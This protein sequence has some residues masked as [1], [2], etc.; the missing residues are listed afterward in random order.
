MSGDRPRLVRVGPAW[1]AAGERWCA[2]IARVLGDALDGGHLLDV[3]HV[4]STAVPGLL[5][6]PTIDL[7]ARVHPWPLPADANARLMR[8]GFVHHDEH[9]LPGRTYYTRGPHEI[10]L[11]VVG[12]GG[13]HWHR[14]VALRDHLRASVE[15]RARYERV[16]HAGLARAQEVPDDREARAAYQDAKAGVIAALEAEA[17]ASALARTGFGPVVELARALADV[18]ARWAVH[19]GWALDLATGAPSRHHED[20]DVAVDA[21]D[22]SAL[23][24]TVTHRGAPVAWV[25]ASDPAAYAPR[26]PG[27]AHPAG[28]HQA[29][30]RWGKTWVDVVLEPWSDAAW[31]YR[32]DPRVT[33]PLDRAIRRVAVE[34]VT[35][36]VLAPE[37]VLLFKATTGG[38]S[39]PRPKDEADLALVLPALDA[40]ARAW[41]RSSLPDGHPWRG[42][43]ADTTT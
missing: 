9:C 36:P 40:D 8:L 3:A 5:A 2:R 11:H 24:D 15:A 4:G 10:H 19:G 37:A 35:V 39:T 29:H 20:V 12:R 23:L 16:K 1:A 21:A 17:L 26:R 22:A 25:I 42:R 43:L 14:H 31:R 33:L 7:L 38:R 30:A 27:E 32:H 41:L 28:G 18:P 6:K 34:G 13:S